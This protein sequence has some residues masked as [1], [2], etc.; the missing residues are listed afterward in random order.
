[1]KAIVY[2]EY[3]SPDVLRREDIETPVPGDKE[4]LIKIRAA[5]LNALDWRMLRGKPVFARVM[6]GGLLKPK[7]TTPGVDLA[8]V[9]EA[10]G[11]EVTKFKAGDEVFGVGRG[12]LAEYVCSVEDKLALKPAEVSFEEAAA[13]PVAGV[14][15]LQGL[16]DK[17]HIRQGQ[18]VLIDGAS[19][20]VGTFAVQI[21]KSFEAEVTAVSSTAKLETARSLGADHVIDYTREDFTQNGKLYDLILGANATHSI[22]AYRRSLMP[23]GSY[24]MVGAVTIA[25]MLQPLILARLLSLFGDKHLN[26]SVASVNNKDLAILGAL[27][28][29]GTI[30]SVI[31]RRYPLTDTPEAFRY[32]EQKHARGKIVITP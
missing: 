15:A 31:D 12:S 4:V 26:F 7:V 2:H 16:R 22:F 21:A 6:I 10:V 20:G 19:G 23:G 3:G 17:G 18:K 27:L 30:T 13:V 32:M 29:A 1:M 28:A 14:T 9:V 5:A 25:T 11:R 8:G 24:V